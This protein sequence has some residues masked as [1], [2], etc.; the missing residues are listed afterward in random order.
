M[1]QCTAKS[2]QSGQ[3]CRRNA[4][5]G[6][7]KCYIHGGRTPSKHGAYSKKTKPV[8]ETNIPDEYSNDLIKV[9]EDI[10]KAAI[11]QY[12]QL[13]KANDLYYQEREKTAHAGLDLAEISQTGEQKDGTE[14]KTIHRQNDFSTLLNAK[15]N[16]ITRLSKSIL[17]MKKELGIVDSTDKIVFDINFG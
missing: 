5:P 10:L 12:R 2:K 17:E 15:A 9:N 13:L 1:S 7:D 11:D 14:Y 4:V 3:R 8:I 6:K 16:L